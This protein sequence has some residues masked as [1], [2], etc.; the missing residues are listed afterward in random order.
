VK[1]NNM[2]LIVGGSILASLVILIA[3]VLWL[4]ETSVSQKQVTYAALFSNVGTLQI[5]DPVMVNG[6]SKGSVADILLRDNKVAVIL[7]LDKKITLTD[8]S[9]VTIQNIGLMGER[10][11]GINLSAQGTKIAP[12]SN[13]DTT[14]LN[15]NFDT[16]I[17]E[18]MGMLGIVLGEVQTLVSN[19]SSILENTVGDSAFYSVFGSLVG[20]LDTITDNVQVLLKKNE[21]MLNKSFKN[22]NEI[23]EDLKNLLDKNSD[24]LSSIVQNG[25]SLSSYAL[26]LASRV[27]SLALSVQNIVDDIG[28][29]EGTVGLLLKDDQFFYDIKKTV[30]NLDTLV[31]QVQDDALKLRIKLGFGRK[32]K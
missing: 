12:T 32:R 1:K 28:N 17:A 7:K 19:V 24:H 27:E 11:V 21:P 2:D 10:G 20:R 6:V 31:N 14:F 8:S 5:G 15:G 16:G 23:T 18:A 22:I 26:I 29:G 4:K 25:D 13:N 9:S 3:G 30:N